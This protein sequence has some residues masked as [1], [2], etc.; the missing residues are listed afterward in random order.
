MS[1]TISRDTYYKY[2]DCLILHDEDDCDG[3]YKTYGEM[4]LGEGYRIIEEEN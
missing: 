2:K 3:K 4:W 1:K